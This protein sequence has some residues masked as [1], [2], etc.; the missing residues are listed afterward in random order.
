MSNITFDTEGK[1]KTM[2]E[3]I[4]WLRLWCEDTNDASLPRV[5][6]VGDSITEGYFRAVFNALKGVAHVDVLATSYS[7]LS[8]AYQNTVK[9][10]IADS[11]Y[12][13]V[14]Y[15]YGLHAYGVDDDA[16]ETECSAMLEFIAK[17]A[18]A[19]VA[20]TTTVLE[21]DLKTESAYWKDKVLA[22]NARLTKVAKEKGLPVD[23]LNALSQTLPGEYRAP[24]GVHFSEKGYQALAELVADSVKQVLK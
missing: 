9:S 6:L 18:K 17:R 16:Y 19:V 2:K 24:D 3:D 15:N 4:E 12:V 1:T 23:D 20:T 22:R 10:F 7:I 8:K 21:S 14:H 13:V 5:A 11:D